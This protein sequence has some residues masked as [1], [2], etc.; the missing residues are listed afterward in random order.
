MKNLF[1]QVVEACGGSIKTLS[2]G[3]GTST[4]AIYKWKKKGRIPAIRRH[5]IEALSGG[6]I[7]AQMIVDQ[8]PAATALPVSTVKAA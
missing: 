5:Q 3:L 2:E 7:T 4:Q 1:E 8:S 6:K